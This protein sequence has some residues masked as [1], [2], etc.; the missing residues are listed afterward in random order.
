MA[1]AHGSQHLGTNC[2][3]AQQNLDWRKIA[4]ATHGVNL[5]LQHPSNIYQVI[6]TGIVQV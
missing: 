1:I 2:V 3:T 6:E 4:V 5:V